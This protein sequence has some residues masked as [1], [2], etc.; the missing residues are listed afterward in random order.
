MK[1]K[2]IGGIV[3][4]VLG[5]LLIVLSAYIKGQIGS[6]RETVQKGKGLFSNNPI[7]KS[8]GGFMED[9]AESKIRQYEGIARWSL[10]GGIVLVII[11]GVGVI[12]SRRK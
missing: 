6:A 7:G 2:F 3:A 1:A 10:Y 11:G 5:A 12:F 4:V 8:V 9:A